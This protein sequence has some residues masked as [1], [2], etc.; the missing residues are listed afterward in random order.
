MLIKRICSN[1]LTI[2]VVFLAFFSYAISAEKT[3]SRNISINKIYHKSDK[4][5]FITVHSYASPMS[6]NVHSYIIESKN[7]LVIIDVQY[8]LSDAKALRDYANK[9]KKKI[10]AV[11]VTHS[12]PDHYL[13]LPVFKDLQTYAL[14]DTI[15]NINLKWSAVVDAL[16]VHNVTD[17][18][19][20]V[21][22]PKNIIKPTF[23]ID[24]I[25]Y[26]VGS[27]PMA[28]IDDGA[29][30][31]LKDYKA[32]FSG[33]I[34]ILKE[35]LFIN[36]FEDYKIV[37]EALEKKLPEYKYDFTGHSGMVNFSD[38]MKTSMDYLKVA[39]KVFDKSKSTEDYIKEMNSLYPQYE[40][41]LAE[42]QTILFKQRYSK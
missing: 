21:E 6:L 34:T 42:F 16:K 3:P 7:N 17:V 36:S 5:N 4:N 19:T 8:N 28:H 13:G 9:L 25:A 14:S 41:I 33:D 35:H 27:Y 37:L 20:A 32:L 29:V 10:A 2:V 26:E 23:V 24:G 30:V 12:H 31:F 1:I 22:L 38:S 39:K 11:I 40:G 18:Q 15:T